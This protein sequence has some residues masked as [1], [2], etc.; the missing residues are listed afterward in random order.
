MIRPNLKTKQVFIRKAFIS[1]I[2]VFILFK[3]LKVDLNSFF[4]KLKSLNLV[5]FS[6][7]SLFAT[8][9]IF[10]NTYR[11]WIITKVFKYNFSYIRGLVWYFE[12]MFANNF[13]PSNIGGDALRAYYLA[14]TNF[15]DEEKNENNNSIIEAGLTV[16]LERL[17]GFI[18][19]F[20][21]Y[22]LE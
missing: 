8:I 13:F 17:F 5:Y 10:T 20:F 22:P 11:W 4:E 15:T 1:C 6:L 19:M 7:A 16:F 9:C 2:F 12:G 18:M 14:N 3:I 21:F